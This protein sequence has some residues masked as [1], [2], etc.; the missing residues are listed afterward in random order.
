MLNQTETIHGV[1]VPLFI[2]LIVTPQRELKL[3]HLFSMW[4]HQL[5]ILI[6]I[7]D[8]FIVLLLFKL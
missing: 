1:T 3:A 6:D 4:R 8:I 7:I 5:T 2:F